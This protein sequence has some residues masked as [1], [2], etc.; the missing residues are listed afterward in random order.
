MLLLAIMLLFLDDRKFNYQIYIKLIMQ[1]SPSKKANV[2][3]SKAV[4]EKKG[5]SI[6]KKEGESDDDN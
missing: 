3:K 6:I 5:I 2:P 4:S 1:K